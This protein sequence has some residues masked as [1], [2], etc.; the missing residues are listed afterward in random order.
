LS[1]IT[2]ALVATTLQQAQGCQLF[3]VGTGYTPTQIDAAAFCSSFGVQVEPCSDVGGGSNIGWLD[4]NDW[5]TWNIDVKESGFYVVRY[6]LASFSGDGAFTLSLKTQNIAL[7]DKLPSTGWWQNWETVHDLVELQ[8]GQKTLTL[9]ILQGGFNLNWIEFEKLNESNC[10]QFQV[11]FGPV[12]IDESAFCSSYGVQVE[13]TNDVGGGTNVGYLGRGDWMS[14]YA[15]VTQGGDYIIRYR[16]ASYSGEGSFAISNGTT[17]LIISDPFP[18]TGGW[19]NWI[20]IEQEI[21]LEA[22]ITQLVLTVL[23]DG[24]NIHWLDISFSGVLPM[25]PSQGPTSEQSRTPSSFPSRFPSKTPSLMPTQ[26][27]SALPSKSPSQSPTL[28]V[29]E[30]PVGNSPSVFPSLAPFKQPDAVH[31][32]SPTDYIDTGVKSSK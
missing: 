11:G 29:V 27:P 28:K 17:S 10:Q 16:I 3:G 18:S 8:S 5:V 15:D 24:W 9:R 32:N 2:I 14:W 19:Q 6:R 13:P 23:D 7:R 26:L 21:K 4:V 31:S 30:L 20:T 12:Q 22:G 25:S 1:S